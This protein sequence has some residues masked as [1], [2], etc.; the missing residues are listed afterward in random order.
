M[1]NIEGEKLRQYIDK[2]E[3][4]NEDMVELREAINDVFRQAKNDGFDTKIMKRVIK[5]KQMKAEDRENE[6][7][8]LCTYMHALGIEMGD[9]GDMGDGA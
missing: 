7:M 4:M 8:L 1:Q 9:S 6:D 5:L 2:I 3:N